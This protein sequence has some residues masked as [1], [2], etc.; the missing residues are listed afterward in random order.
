M[1][2]GGSLPSRTTDSP[3]LPGWWTSLYRFLVRQLLCNVHIGCVGK[4]KHFPQLFF[5]NDAYPT[6]GLGMP[7]QLA[8][9]VINDA[10]APSFMLK[11]IVPD[12]HLR[13][14]TPMLSSSRDPVCC[15]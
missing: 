2:A 9:P 14:F 7:G 3:S 1:A 15:E 13:S 12:L 6:Q 8:G 10:F 11:Q 4:F 5:V